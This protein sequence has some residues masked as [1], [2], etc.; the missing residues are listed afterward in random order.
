MEDC[1]LYLY[2]NIVDLIKKV[3][4]GVYGFMSEM[5]V[6]FLIFEWGEVEIVFLIID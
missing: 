5:L 6:W 2:N 3:V 1:L 4:G